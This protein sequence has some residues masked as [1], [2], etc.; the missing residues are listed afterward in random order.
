MAQAVKCDRCGEFKEEDGINQITLPDGLSF[1]K[2]GNGQT[3]EVDLCT[4]KEKYIEVCSSCAKLLEKELSKV[5]KKWK[6][7]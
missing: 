3:R 6:K 1:W 4:V 2:R 7:G 5:F